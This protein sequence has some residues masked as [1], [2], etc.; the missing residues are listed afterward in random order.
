MY[1]KYQL[2]ENDFQ[3]LNSENMGYP[4]NIPKAKERTDIREHLT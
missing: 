3:S 4:K 1:N 2:I